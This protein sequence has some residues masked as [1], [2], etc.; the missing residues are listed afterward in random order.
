MS[1]SK[2]RKAFLIWLGV[3]VPIVIGLIIIGMNC[4][5]CVDQCGANVR[6][7]EVVVSTPEKLRWLDRPSPGA[8]PAI[9]GAT[10]RMGASNTF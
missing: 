10:F 4:E 9:S 7:G 6:P 2:Y 8:N 1:M 5:S 3:M